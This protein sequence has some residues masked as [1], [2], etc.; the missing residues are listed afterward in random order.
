MQ[1]DPWVG[2]TLVTS[3]YP[4]QVKATLLAYSK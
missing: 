2:Q 4:K 1:K 3:D